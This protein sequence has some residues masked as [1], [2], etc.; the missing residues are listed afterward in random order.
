MLALLDSRNRVVHATSDANVGSLAQLTSMIIRYAQ[1]VLGAFESGNELDHT[2]IRNAVKA[3]LEH[4][5]PL[6]L[7]ERQA[8][9]K[10]LRKLSEFYQLWGR[11]TV[12]PGD[13]EVRRG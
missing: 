11:P 3:E 2:L 10:R 6:D 8:S 5:E 4:I 13:A 12:I 7:E 9:A 1:T